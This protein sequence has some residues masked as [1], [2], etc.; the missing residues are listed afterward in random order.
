VQ[1][2]SNVIPLTHGI[3]AGRALGSGASISS[4]GHLLFDE[5]LV[6]FVYLL[7]GI[8]MLRW[9]EYASRRSAALEA[10]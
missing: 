9:F 6:G 10:F 4:T 3:E 7:L 1:A 8:T 5:L 2:I